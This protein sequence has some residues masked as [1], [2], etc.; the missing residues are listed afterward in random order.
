VAFWVARGKA[1]TRSSAKRRSAV[2]VAA[3]AVE[4]AKSA[5]A[6]AGKRVAKA[7]KAKARTEEYAAP[8]LRCAVERSGRAIAAGKR[9]GGDVAVGEAAR[10]P[11]R[12]SQGSGASGAKR[13]CGKGS[14]SRVTVAVR[15]A[16]EANACNSRARSTRSRRLLWSG[17]GEE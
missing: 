6:L 15:A 8:R 16:E 17:A 4:K 13:S 9:V 5:T 12:A 10:P 14:P 2:D 11:T 7:A 1:A 3:A